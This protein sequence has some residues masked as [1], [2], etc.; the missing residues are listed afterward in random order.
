MEYK[1]QKYIIEKDEQNYIPVEKDRGQPSSQPK[2]MVLP[3]KTNGHKIIWF[4]MN[5]INIK[6]SFQENI[7]AIV[8]SDN[9]LQRKEL[10][11]GE[12]TKWVCEEA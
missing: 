5:R 7:V 12:H 4:L 3:A 11:V 10:T 9:Y 8:V 6:S 1:G 2:I